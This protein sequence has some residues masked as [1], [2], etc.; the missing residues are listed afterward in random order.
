[1]V[2]KCKKRNTRHVKFPIF[3]KNRKKQFFE[4]KKIKKSDAQ[5]GRV[6]TFHIL[7]T[8]RKGPLT[9]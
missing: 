7:Q 3:R 5:V 4:N 2:Q 9:H 6:Y 8:I 1:M